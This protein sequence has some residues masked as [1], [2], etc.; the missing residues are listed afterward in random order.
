MPEIRSEPSAES[1]TANFADELP[2]FRTRTFN[3]ASAVRDS[4]IDIGS[5]APRCRGASDV[6]DD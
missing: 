3:E 4:R 1:M 2:Q 5:A 6:D